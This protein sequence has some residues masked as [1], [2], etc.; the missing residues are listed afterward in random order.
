MDTDASPSQPPFAYVDSVEIIINANVSPYPDP[1][2]VTNFP[3]AIDPAKTPM[4]PKISGNSYTPPM[5]YGTSGFSAES[6]RYTLDLNDDGVV[7]AGDQAVPLAT[8]A[9]RTANPDDY[10]IARST[11]G[12]R[13]DGLNGGSL[14]KVGL[15]RGP[16]SGVPPLYTV[17][18]G[19]TKPEGNHV[20]WSL[21]V[22]RFSKAAFGKLV[23]ER[24][25]KINN[26][27]GDPGILISALN[28]TPVSE[29]TVTKS[30]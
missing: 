8:E 20:A 27:S 23:K 1:G 19:S 2:G 9:Q 15:V 11:Y 22:D 16:G 24:D 10:V 13:L 5:L 25:A 17:Y 3:R 4:P 30:V 7:D 12:L 14:E 6:I 29:V 26:G 28:T 18:L 21:R